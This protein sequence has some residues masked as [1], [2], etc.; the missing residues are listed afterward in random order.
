MKTLSKLLLSL[1]LSFGLNNWGLIASA[2]NEQ[3]AAGLENFLENA[4]AEM[5]PQEQEAF[6]MEVQREQEKLM[7][8]SPAERA[9]KEKEVAEQLDAL[10]SQDSPYQELFTKPAPRSAEAHP[11]PIEKPIKKD[12]PAIPTNPTKAIG[13]KRI[14]KP[15]IPAELKATSKE[16]AQKIAHAIDTILIKTNSM[17]AVIHAKWNQSEWQ[18]FQDNLQTLQSQLNMIVNSDLVLAEFIKTER[19]TLRDDLM[20]FEAA[21]SPQAKNLKTPDAMGLV[22]IFEG[23]TKVID[24]VRYESSIVQLQKIANSLNQQLNQKDL[25][26]RIKGLVNQHAPA[27]SKPAIS[28]P[29]NSSAP[30]TSKSTVKACPATDLATRTAQAQALATAVQQTANQGLLDL[31]IEYQNAPTINLSR[32]LQW[33]LSELEAQLSKLTNCLI[34]FKDQEAVLGAKSNY[35]LLTKLNTLLNTLTLDGELARLANQIQAHYQKLF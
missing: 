25:I 2:L 3:H 12:E 34:D 5:S 22:V 7:K 18:K 33:R 8:M 14:T 35:A 15:N 32:K 20:S 24:P 23:R 6:M 4:F 11:T 29:I 1:L 16:L 28:L 13:S 21:I 17:Q 31:C 30:Q 19:Q 27:K 26:N 9:Q 10:M